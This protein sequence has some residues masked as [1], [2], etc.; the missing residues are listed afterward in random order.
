[1]LNKRFWLY[2][3]ECV[4]R[5]RFMSFDTLEEAIAYRDEFDEN[6]EWMIFDSD[7]ILLASQE[8]DNGE[9]YRRVMR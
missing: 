2:H 6:D 9:T 4:P 1:M 5:E 7:I 8:W 3:F